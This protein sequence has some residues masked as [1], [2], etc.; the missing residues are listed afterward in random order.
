MKVTKGPDKWLLAESLFHDDEM[1]NEPVTLT[2]T[3]EYEGREHRLHVVVDGID[4]VRSEPNLFRIK[5]TGKL[6]TTTRGESE[7]VFE[8]LPVQVSFSTRTRTGV[9]NASF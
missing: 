3:V 7:P 9:A 2:F 1:P 5:G 6:R 4:R 8:H